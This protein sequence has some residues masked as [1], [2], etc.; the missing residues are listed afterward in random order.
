MK[1]AL[2]SGDVLELTAKHLVPVTRDDGKIEVIM[3]RLVRLDDELTVVGKG[4]QRVVAIGTTA[5]TGGAFAPFTRAGT[6]A[7]NGV[8]A[9][10]YAGDFWS[11]DRLLSAQTAAKL[12]LVPLVAVHALLPYSAATAALEQYGVGNPGFHP[13]VAGLRIAGAFKWFP[14]CGCRE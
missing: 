6:I 3:A 1:L 11:G 2:A 4:R 10:C 13:C 5:K 7:I 12:S 14:R 9:S 8:V